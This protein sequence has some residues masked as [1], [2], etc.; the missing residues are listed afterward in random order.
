MA[1]YEITDSFRVEVELLWAGGKE[2]FYTEESYANVAKRPRYSD[3]HLIKK[4]GKNSSLKSFLFMFYVGIVFDEITMATL[5][6]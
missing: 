6:I 1:L 3:C 2:A 5:V 4:D